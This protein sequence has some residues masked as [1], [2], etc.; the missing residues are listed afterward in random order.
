MCRRVD[1]RKC[2]RPTFTGC[3][4]HVE[5]VLG[6]VPRAERC[7]CREEQPKGS[8]GLPRRSSARAFGRDCLER[9]KESNMT[10]ERAIR[11][12]AG[13]LVLTSLVL[14]LL[15]GRWWLLLAIFVGANLLSSAFTNFCP[16]EIAM[17]RLRLFEARP[18]GGAP[19][20]PPNE[21]G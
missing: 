19:E 9:R 18:A 2:G 4:A 1:C 17:R 16:A 13:T 5:Q 20:R 10:V 12:L 11:A 14:S 7:R 15:V 3:G 21:V 8:A 6:D